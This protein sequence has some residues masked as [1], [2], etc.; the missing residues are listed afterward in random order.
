MFDLASTIAP[1]SLIRFT[2]NASLFETKPASASEPLALC[3]PDRFKVVFDNGR[4]AVQRPNEAALRGTAI[5]IVGLLQRIWIDEDDGVD[6]RPVL[7]VRVDPTNITLDEA[8]A[9]DATGLERLVNLRNRGFLDLE[10]R[11][12]LR[13]WRG[14]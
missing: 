13:P 14:E 4:H 7:V 2:R 12:S 8:V 1:A 10:R 11:W 3:S 5:E 9:G 6:R